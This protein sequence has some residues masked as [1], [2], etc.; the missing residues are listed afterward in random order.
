[1][2]LLVLMPPKCIAAP[3]FIVVSAMASGGQPIRAPLMATTPI[4]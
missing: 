1:M 2:P 4:R 3:V